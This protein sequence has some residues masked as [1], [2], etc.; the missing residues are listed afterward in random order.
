[1]APELLVSWAR[2]ARRRTLELIEDLS[3]AQML[4]PHLATVNPPL[5]EIGHL[6]WFQE[7]WLLRRGG[8]PSLRADAD[9]LYDSSAVAHATRWDLALPSR[10]DTLAYM[11]Q[12]LDRVGDKLDRGPVSEED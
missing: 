11:R 1:M 8:G 3:D 5:W 10:R 4:G 12:V 7:K 2:D 9:A 6:A